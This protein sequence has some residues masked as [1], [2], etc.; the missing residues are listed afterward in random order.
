MPLKDLLIERINNDELDL[1]LLPE[2]ANRVIQLTNDPE[3]DAQQLAQLIQSDQAL[4]SHVMKIANSALYSPNSA[5]VSL[6]QAIARIGFRGITDIALSATINAKLF[7]VPGFEQEVQHLFHYAL[8]TGLWAKEIARACRKN[9]EAAFLAG[10]LHNIG[11]PA[12]IHTLLELAKSAHVEVKK[13]EI[14]QLTGELHHT[15]ASSVVKAWNMP[16]TVCTVIE[17]F[18]Q[19]EKDHAEQ[20][21]TRIVVGGSHLA[22]YM[23]GGD[24]D[25]HK[26]SQEDIMQDDVLA[27]LNLYQ[28]DV[29][30]LLDKKELVAQTLGAMSP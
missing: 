2:V 20:G 9:V 8:G 4:A 5:M 3:S 26:T 16:K 22:S 29:E 10:L 1:P 19:H 7:K 21:L 6:Q 18:H 12:C 11:K 17:Y 14:K 13:D 27:Q 28:N 15:F 24:F 25:G 23:I 30:L